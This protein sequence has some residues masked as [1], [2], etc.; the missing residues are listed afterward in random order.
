MKVFVT[1]GTGAIGRHAI[2][3][4][5]GAGHSVSALARTPEKAAALSEHG[6]EP[7]AVSSSATASLR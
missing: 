1:G 4:L 3:A 2:P 7:I 5:V 6:A